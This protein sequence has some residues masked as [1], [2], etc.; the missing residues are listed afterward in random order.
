MCRQ[1]VFQ[2]AAAD[3]KRDD[4]RAG[5]SGKEALTFENLMNSPWKVR[6]VNERQPAAEALMQH[7]QSLSVHLLPV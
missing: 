1:A 7:C 6:P 4:K 2:F 3:K 5:E